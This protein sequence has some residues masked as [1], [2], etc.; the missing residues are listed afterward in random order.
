MFGTVEEYLKY[1]GYRG[2]HEYCGGYSVVRKDTT[3]N[4]GIISTVILDS[5]NNTEYA[6]D[7]TEYPPQYWSYLQ[8][9]LMVLP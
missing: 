7:K 1:L 5:L 4:L 8:I 3:T 2:S 9:V 6:L